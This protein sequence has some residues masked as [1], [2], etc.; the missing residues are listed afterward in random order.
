MRP[1]S[2][3][4]DTI[5]P[6]RAWHDAGVVSAVAKSFVGASR[7][8]FLPGG[9]A[10][11]ADPGR[12]GAV[13]VWA[14]L[15]VLWVVF[16]GQV[17]I[18]WMTSTDGSFGPAT[19]PGPDEFDTWRLVAMRV[20]EGI[21]VAI[22]VAMAWICLVRP[23]LQNRR[24]GLDGMLFIAATLAAPIDPL[25][26]YFHWTFAWNSHAINW[27][28]WGHLFPLSN[29]PHYA[30]GFVWFV[31]QYVYLGLGFAMIECGVIL[32]LRQRYPAISNVKAFGIAAGLTFLVDVCVEY[33]F[34]LT[35]I[36]AYPRTIGAFTLFAG[37][38]YQFPVY[39]SLFVTAYATGFTLLRMSAYDDPGGLSFVERGIHR[40]R[41]R[42]RFLV[43]QLALVGF[44]AFWA[45][46]TYFLPWSWLS[47]SVDSDVTGLLPSYLLP[48]RL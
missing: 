34:I 8:Q 48:S 38:Q 13:T 41:P 18:R 24:I 1:A 3:V 47:V 6:D 30:E 36:Y 5:G 45:A 21:S 25:I 9:G 35:E 44:C 23:W 19:I 22:M 29:A 14:S 15:G 28:S 27:G 10:A 11:T 37:S 39:E 4:T 32:I 20:I 31:P 33:L 26:N 40:V 46:V 2:D 16:I 12:T 17:F 7:P 43:R 42:A